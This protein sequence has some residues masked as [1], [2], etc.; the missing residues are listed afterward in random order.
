VAL[1]ENLRKK[2]RQIISDVIYLEIFI[3]REK[4]MEKNKGMCDG[5]PGQRKG[6]RN[7]KKS[8]VRFKYKQ[9]GNYWEKNI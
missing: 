4:E 1:C 8:S 5:D 6:N 7:A 2:T 9:E 3:Q